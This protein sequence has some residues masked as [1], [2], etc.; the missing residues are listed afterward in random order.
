MQ[1]QG[2]RRQ[3]YG[4]YLAAT[5]LLISKRTELIVLGGCQLA[6]KP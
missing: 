3:I 5:V 6:K 4:I 2:S 1:E